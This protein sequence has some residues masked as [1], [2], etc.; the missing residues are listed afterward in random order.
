MTLIGIILAVAGI[1]VAAVLIALLRWM[2]KNPEIVND[3]DE[4][5]P[6]FG[7]R[8]IIAI[9]GLMSLALIVAGELCIWPYEASINAK[10]IFWDAN[11]SIL[12]LATGLLLAIKGYSCIVKLR[13]AKLSASDSGGFP[14]QVYQMITE[15]CA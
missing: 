8:T 3:I 9:F 15:K 7:K 12:T 5:T 13:I 14:E 1:L 6:V 4:S 11:A 10:T 2:G